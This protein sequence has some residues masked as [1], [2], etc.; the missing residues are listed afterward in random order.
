MCKIVPS[1]THVKSFGWCWLSL[2]FDV[3]MGVMLLDVVLV[4]LVGVVCLCVD[5]LMCV[6]LLCV[7]LMCLFGVVCLYFDSQYCVSGV[8]K[9]CNTL[10]PACNA[11]LYWCVKLMNGE[12]MPASKMAA[13]EFSLLN[14]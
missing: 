4:W 10:V 3:L 13:T 7:V 8:E 1:F 14:L 6:L 11:N 12:T 2:C 5:V 9:A